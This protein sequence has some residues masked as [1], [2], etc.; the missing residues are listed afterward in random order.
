MK[1]Y[2]C[3][4]GTGEILELDTDCNPSTY[5]FSS[6]GSLMLELISRLDPK[7]KKSQIFPILW[8]MAS[9]NSAE[10]G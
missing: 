3:Y 10:I 2:F 6:S 1:D 4:F 9:S 7:E 5:Y 8:N